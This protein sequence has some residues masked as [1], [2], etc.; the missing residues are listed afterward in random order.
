MSLAPR[1]QASG[2]MELRDDIVSFS[3]PPEMVM[4]CWTNV[5]LPFPLEEPFFLSPWLR[6]LFCWCPDSSP[7]EW[8]SRLAT[9]LV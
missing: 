1:F 8:T 4:R 6:L 3:R 7:L 5:T 2:V 9:V